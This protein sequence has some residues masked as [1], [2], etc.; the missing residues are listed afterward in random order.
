MLLL[1]LLLLYNASGITPSHTISN[2]RA[3]THTYMRR[4]EYVVVLCQANDTRVNSEKYFRTRGGDGSVL[5]RSTSSSSSFLRY[6]VSPRMHTSAYAYSVVFRRHCVHMH[7]S[8]A[9]FRSVGVV[10]RWTTTHWIRRFTPSYV[11]LYILGRCVYSLRRSA[12]LSRISNRMNGHWANCIHIFISISSLHLPVANDWYASFVVGR[13][14]VSNKLHH[15]EMETN[16]TSNTI[17]SLPVDDAFEFYFFGCHW[18][19]PRRSKTIVAQ[20]EKNPNKCNENK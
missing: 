1:L 20:P 12:E 4:C 19:E 15:L 9:L 6:R 17:N 2:T 14:R 18:G 16:F 13:G 8:N 11:C 3:H 10:R 5:G 7:T